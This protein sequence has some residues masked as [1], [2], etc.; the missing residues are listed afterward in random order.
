MGEPTRTPFY[1]ETETEM[2]ITTRAIALGFAFVAAIGA[3]PDI[4]SLDWAEGKV[5]TRSGTLVDT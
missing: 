5:D 3:V 1:T 2:C 4:P